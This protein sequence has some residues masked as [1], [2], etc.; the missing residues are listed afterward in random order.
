MP[1]TVKCIYAAFEESACKASAV[2]WIGAS[3]VIR[4]KNES[5]YQKDA[6]RIES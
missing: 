5:T 3:M 2:V 1:S 4:I 6:K